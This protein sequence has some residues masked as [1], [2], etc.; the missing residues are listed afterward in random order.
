MK[1]VDI[2]YY[3]SKIKTSKDVYIYLNKII[4][5]I[6]IPKDEIIRFKLKNRDI[7]TNNKVNNISKVKIYENNILV[8]YVMFLFDKNKIFNGESYY[9]KI[10]YNNLDHNDNYF[11]KDFVITINIYLK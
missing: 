3:L 10:I 8:T 1:F 2:I 5:L 7:I 9:S 6:N 11:S 4:E